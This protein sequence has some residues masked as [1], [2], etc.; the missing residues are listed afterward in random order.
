MFLASSMGRIKPSPTLALAAQARALKAGGIDIIDLTVGEPDGD[1]PPFVKEAAI[2]AI[3]EGY[4]K[5]TAVDG[6][7]SLKEAI[8]HKLLRDQGFSYAL[9]EI[10]VGT[11]AKQIIFNALLASLEVGD[12]VV[13]PV[14]GWVSY[15]DIVLFAGGTPIL[16]PC[17]EGEGFKL[18]PENLR[19][20][21]SPRTKWLILN[22]PSN[23]TGSTYSEKEL[24][25]LAE[26]LKDFPQVFVLSDDI[27]E[28][29]VFDNRPFLNIGQVAPFL[30]DRLLVVNGVSKA[31]AM[32]GWRIGYGAGPEFLIKAL[33]MLQSQS[34]SN[35]CAV[36]QKAAEAALLHQ[37]SWL[38]DM[39]QLFQQRRD[40]LMKAF[41]SIPQ[42]TFQKPEGAFYAYLNCQ[43]LL[44]ARTPEGIRLETDQEITEYF[45]KKAL[46]ALVP[47]SAFGLSPYMRLSYA[48]LPSEIMK[49]ADRM[50]R[51]LQEL[52]FS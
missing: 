22:S 18:S 44:G 32:T 43:A 38:A 1:T 34:T 41:E 27:Y 45:L 31:Y 11:G 7:P 23:P 6:L 29:L 13:I 10:I 39:R 40:A 16:V 8:R 28:A 21:L 50:H 26:V 2:R 19:Q 33:T 46:V 30:K 15:P 25:G 51:A 9:S 20:A 48:T 12:E 35:A 37:G 47:G 42:L 24:K 49:A 36:A 52:D 3:Q 14:P 17:P 4:N 5:Y